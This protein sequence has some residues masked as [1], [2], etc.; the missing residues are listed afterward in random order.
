MWELK[1]AAD[2]RKRSIY[3][4]KGSH[5]ASA[6]VITST[7][8]PGGDA[9]TLTHRARWGYPEQ[10]D[11]L[12]TLDATAPVYILKCTCNGMAFIANRWTFT[13]ECKCVHHP[14]PKES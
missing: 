1:T 11:E 13:G 5:L 6:H 7:V 3:V 14:L 10:A 12:V 4:E 9:V 2:L 8:V